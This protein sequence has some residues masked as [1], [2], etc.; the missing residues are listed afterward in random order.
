M[1]H[2]TIFSGKESSIIIQNKKYRLTKASSWWGA[3]C[4]D[5]FMITE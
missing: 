1:P 5:S 3:V 2:D 4:S